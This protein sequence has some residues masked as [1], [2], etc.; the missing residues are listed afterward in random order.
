MHQDGLKKH[1]AETE[2]TKPGFTR[3]VI[4]ETLPNTLI[5][6]MRIAIDLDKS[7]DIIKNLS[8]ATNQI[9]DLAEVKR[10]HNNRFQSSI[11]FYVSSTFHKR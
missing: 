6:L 2:E 4:K 9:I 10:I 5:F 11:D 7:G 3:H 8:Q 1:L